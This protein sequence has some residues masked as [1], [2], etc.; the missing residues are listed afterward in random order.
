[1][2]GLHYHS[3]PDWHTLLAGGHLGPDQVVQEVTLLAGQ[4]HL[5]AADDRTV[6]GGLSLLPLLL[7]WSWREFG[8]VAPGPHVINLHQSLLQQLVHLASSEVLSVGEGYEVN[9]VRVIKDVPRLWRS[10]GRIVSLILGSDVSYKISFNS[11]IY[12]I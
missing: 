10:R 12:M 3:S 1:M 9:L 6:S 5:Q 8:H 11:D 2:P 4:G 7:L